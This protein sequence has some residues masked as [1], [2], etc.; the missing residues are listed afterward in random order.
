MKKIAIILYGTPGSGKGMQ[1]DLLAGKYGLVH[2]D[3]G[4][5]LRSILYNNPA[6]AD[7]VIKRERE[8]NDRGFLN[9]PSWVVRVLKKRIQMLANLGYGVVFSGSPRTL[10]EAEKITPSL[11]KLYGRKNIYVFALEVPLTVAERRN[12]YRL[13]C[14]VC[15]R[16]LLTQYYPVKNPRHC[17]VCAGP[18]ERRIDDNPSK[19]KTRA[20]EYETRT[21]PVIDYLRRRG[22]RIKKIDGQPA[23]YKVFQ[24][25]LYGLKNSG[26][27]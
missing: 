26:R 25:I 17:P 10:Y 15:Q 3:S 21:V 8:L 7:P 24:K 6:K 27:D 9:T 20:K 11:E 4:K 18:L 1:A 12:R 2:F 19:F 22:Y 16:P 5:L 23:P 14:A 13:V